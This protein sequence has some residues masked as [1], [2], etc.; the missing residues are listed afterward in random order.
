ML[1]HY[2]DLINPLKSEHIDALNSCKSQMLAL[3]FFN[4]PHLG[5]YINIFLIPE[6][7]IARSKDIYIIIC[8]AHS[9][10]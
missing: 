1:F 3:S 4:E 7:G 9:W 5:T 10:I 8:E 6:N 2:R